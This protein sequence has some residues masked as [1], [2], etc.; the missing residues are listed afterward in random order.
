MIQDVLNQ[1]DYSLCAEIAL[2]L[3]FLIF[4]VI[5]LKTLLSDRRTLQQ[6]AREALRDSQEP[7]HEPNR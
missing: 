7:P 4:V 2:G 1:I 6:Y 3:F 5:T